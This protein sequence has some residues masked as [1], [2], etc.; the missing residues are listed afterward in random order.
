MLEIYVERNSQH[1][2]END[3]NMRVLLDTKTPFLMD[4]DARERDTVI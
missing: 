3:W 2:K 4:F 1:C